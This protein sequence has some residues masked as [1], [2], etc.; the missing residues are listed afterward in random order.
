MIW[1]LNRG[2]VHNKKFN[3]QKLCFQDDSF[4]LLNHLKTAI[5]RLHFLLLL[6]RYNKWLHIMNHLNPLLWL[7]TTLSYEK[8]TKS[9]K[10][11]K[12]IGNSWLQWTSFTVKTNAFEWGL[13]W[14]SGSFS[15]DSRNQIIWLCGTRNLR[16]DRPNRSLRTSQP[17]I[18]VLYSFALNMD[19][20][21]VVLSQAR[22]RLEIWEWIMGF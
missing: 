8:E 11:S 12:K 3:I 14:G 6:L 4:I 20:N 17:R 1:N 7:L 2:F 19:I 22:E 10:E 15:S 21:Q 9:F 18:D 13:N 16:E 5:E